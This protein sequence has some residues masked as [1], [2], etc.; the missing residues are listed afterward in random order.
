MQILC[1]A[2]LKELKG[3]D[4][5][6]DHKVIDV[7]LI[8]LIYINGGSLQKGMEKILKKKIIE[9]CLNESLFDQCIHGHRELV[10]ASSVS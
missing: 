3:L 6:Q 1:E 8:M 4:Q 9:G 2:I 7:W 10:K 5:P